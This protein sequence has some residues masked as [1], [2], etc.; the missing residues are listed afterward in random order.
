[1]KRSALALIILSGIS[2]LLSPSCSD[3]AT[4][5]GGGGEIPTPPEKPDYLKEVDRLLSFSGSLP[6]VEPGLRVFPAYSG[7]FDPFRTKLVEP[8]GIV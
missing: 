5:G 4:G 6:K 1:M 2:L 8:I 3:R 7:S